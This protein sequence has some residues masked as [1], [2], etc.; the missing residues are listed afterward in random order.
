MQNTIRGITHGEGTRD[1]HTDILPEST[2]PGSTFPPD[3]ATVTVL[4]SMFNYVYTAKPAA[5]TEPLCGVVHHSE[6]LYTRP[7]VS[8]N[9]GQL[10]TNESLG[11]WCTLTW[12]LGGR[13]AMTARVRGQG[14]INKVTMISAVSS[15]GLQCWDHRNVWPAATSHITHQVQGDIRDITHNSPRTGWHQYW[16]ICSLGLTFSSHGSF[17]LLEGLVSIQGSRVKPV[18]PHERCLASSE[19][20]AWHCPGAVSFSP[21]LCHQRRCAA[22]TSHTPMLITP[23]RS[24]GSAQAGRHWLAHSGMNEMSL[25]GW[26]F[27]SGSSLVLTFNISMICGGVYSVWRM[28]TLLLPSMWR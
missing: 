13:P 21:G 16:V 1:T 14:L 27:I 8:H 2:H 24:R 10:V 18:W 22:V 3:R 15:R 23:P 5:N 6:L 4:A 20:W 26:G 11:Q 25:K 17:S 12:W 19:W 28:K 9:N 7:R